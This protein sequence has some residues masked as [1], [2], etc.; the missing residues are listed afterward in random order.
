MEF[1]QNDQ[2]I[3]LLKSDGIPTYHFAHVVDDHFMRTTLV[4]RGEEW[5]A[6]LPVHVELFHALRWDAPQY[7][8]TSHLMK[9]DDGSKR[10]LSKR[11][12]PEL[13]LGFYHEEGYPVLAVTEYLM[14]L[15]NSNFEE[16]RLQNPQAPIG[17]FPFSVEKMGR[18]GA[19][20][21]LN[22]LRDVSKNVISVMDARTVLDQVS[23]WAQK[24]DEVLY[25]LLTA[26][27]S[28]ALSIFSIG[29]GGPKPR[30]D[31]TVW[32]EVKEYV[33]FFYE[34]LFNPR[35]EYPERISREDWINIL[36]RYQTVYDPADD[37]PA[38]FDKIKTL[39][40]G[41]G[42]AP[43]TKL[44]KKN[45]QD[46]KGH[47]GDVSMVLRIAVTGRTNSPDIYEVMKILGK[48]AVISRLK[49]AMAHE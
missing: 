16:W 46:Y 43:E 44:Y 4:V 3:V 25:N 22:K 5:L 30:K 6:T 31:L 40:S 1:P 41:L 36:T 11:K 33:S 10:K 35:Y 19:L 15:L 8:H 45:P 17:E 39:S 48:D 27:P 28:Y 20:F 24:Y 42:Y 7:A 23:L 47:V 18:S 26:N 13:A 37:Q 49:R 2:D 34:E 9:L 29:R 12:D 38:W 32:S 21:D 14:T